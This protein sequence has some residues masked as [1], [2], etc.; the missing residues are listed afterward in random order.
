MKRLI[1]I[2]KKENSKSSD[3]LNALG[4][5]L[6]E[7]MVALSIFLISVLGVFTTFT[8]CINYNAGNSSRNQA[9]AI[10]QR[11]VEQMRSAKF[12]PTV[13]DT[14]LTGG[15]KPLKTV[16]SADGNNYRIQTTVDDDPFTSGTQINSAKTLK[17]IT[18]IVTLDRPA[19]G[20]QT[21]VPISMVMRRVRAN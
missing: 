9:L 4:F 19:P 14:T 11:E 10:L 2:F 20:W 12:T 7:A 13:T 8:Y 1:R 3:D 6:I 21:S 17:E 5:S 16:I 15:A 18:I